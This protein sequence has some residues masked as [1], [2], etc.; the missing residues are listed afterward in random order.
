MLEIKQIEK[1]DIENFR[2]DFSLP[3][4]TNSICDYYLVYDN[5]T[6]DKLAVFDI[7]KSTNAIKQMSIFYSNKFKD[8]TD[9]KWDVLEKSMAAFNVVAMIFK[10]VIDND[11]NVE[12]TKIYSANNYEYAIFSIMARNLMEQGG[13]NIKLYTKWIEITKEA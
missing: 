12:T 9:Y 10:Y 1:R 2:N 5:D 8:T 7:R 11:Y 4:D 13:Y 6:A 3:D